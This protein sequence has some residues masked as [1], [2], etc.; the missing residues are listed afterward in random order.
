[1]KNAQPAPEQVKKLDSF[2]AT[3][4][5]AESAAKSGKLARQNIDY[6]VDASGARK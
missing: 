3:K 1:M 2:A 6:I 5:Q 4:S